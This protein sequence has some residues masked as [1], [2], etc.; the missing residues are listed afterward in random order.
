LYTR[1]PERDKTWV[2]FLVFCGVILSLH[3]LVHD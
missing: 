1:H 3:L 2:K